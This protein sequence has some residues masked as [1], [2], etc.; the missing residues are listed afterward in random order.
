LKEEY[1]SQDGDTGECEILLRLGTKDRRKGLKLADEVV[2]DLLS[3][4]TYTRRHMKG[5]PN[6]KKSLEKIEKQLWR[7][8]RG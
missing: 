8:L 5:S 4:C 2:N 6:F 3:A 7:C 1:L